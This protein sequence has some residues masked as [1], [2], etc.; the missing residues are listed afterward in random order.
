MTAALWILAV[1]FVIVGIAGIVL[2]ALPGVVLVFIGLLLAAWA[3]GFQRIGWVTISLLAGMTVLALITD[4]LATTLGVKR[5]GA[6]RWAIIGSVIG[7]VAGLLFGLIG[8]ILGPFVGA[9]AGEYYARRDMAQAGRAGFGTWAGIILGT[10]V[11]LALAF[12]M[13]ALFAASYVLN[14]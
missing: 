6:S 2:P 3:D 9:A 7:T 14:E 1:L 11:K 13:M 12:S 10:A 4:V 8:I 5:V